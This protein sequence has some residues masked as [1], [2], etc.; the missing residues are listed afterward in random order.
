MAS[1][2]ILGAIYLF[3]GN[4]APRGYALCQGQLMSISQNAALFSI[5][6]TTY[7]GDGVQTFGLPDLRGRVAVGAGQGPNLTNIP[8]G[9]SKGLQN[10]TLGLTNMPSHN[11]L[12]NCDSNANDTTALSPAGNFASA[13]G[14]V[15]GGGTAVPN[16]SAGP[17]NATMAA[18]SLTP[19]GGGAAFSIQN[20]Y[21]GLSYIIATQGLFPSRN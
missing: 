1:T 19:V 9:E 15:A 13:Q 14:T 2:P 6:G 8:L 11:H 12:V 10:V 3:A 16:F 4:F 7:G 17:A 21:L 5:L 18:T 20:P